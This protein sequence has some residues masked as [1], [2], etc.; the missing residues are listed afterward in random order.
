MSLR[1]VTIFGSA[2]AKESDASYQQAL[3]VGRLLAQNDFTVCN[4]GYRGIM[5]ASARGACEAGGK[6]LGI[7][8]VQFAGKV[9]PWI[10][11]ERSMKTW[12]DRLFSLI[13]TGNAY[14][15]FNGGT[16]T[17]TELFVVWEMTNK[18]LLKNPIILIGDFLHALLERLKKENAVL[19]NGYLKIAK[20]PEE[21]LRYL[22][23]T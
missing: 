22:K 19:F 16:G 23:E 13:E 10:Q 7:T 12:K 15:L 11:E 17:L 3:H 4:G 1:I 8:T 9:N 20:T 6:T 18:G 21:V 2:Q 14:V 5:E